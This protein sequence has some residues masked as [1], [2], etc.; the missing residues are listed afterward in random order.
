MANDVLRIP[1]DPVVST[2]L[3]AIG[4]D[5]ARKI[6]A[7]KF[8]SS[9]AIYHYAGVS[10]ETAFAFQHAES[11]GTYFARGIKGLYQGEKMTGPCP[12]CGDTGWIGDKCEDCGCATYIAE[13]PKVVDIVTADPRR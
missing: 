11:K 9:G 4:Y 13:A 10:S 5:P 1:L 12:A 7:V 2:N 8:R 6:L 3:A